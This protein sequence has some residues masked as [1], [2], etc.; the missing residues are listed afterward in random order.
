MTIMEPSRLAKMFALIGTVTLLALAIACAKAPLPSSANSKASAANSIKRL[1]EAASDFRAELTTDRNEIVAQ[2]PTSLILNVRNAKGEIVRDLPPVHEKPIHLI[3]VSGDLA[4]FNHLHP[5][6]QPDGSYRVG[7][8]FPHGGSYRLY[9]DFTPT[10]A[11]QIVERYS[12][13][14]SGT[15]AQ[16]VTLME[17][18]SFAKSSEGLRVNMQPSA[19]LRAGREVQL[20][21][22][23]TDEASGKPVTDLQPYLGSL[24]HFVI[25]T[26][27][28]TKYLHVHP[29]EAGAMPGMNDEGMMG[30]MD[31]QMDA[32]PPR[33]AASKLTVSAH[34]TFADAGLYKLWAQFQRAGRVITIP[35]I[36][37]VNGGETADAKPK[38][39][40]SLP[41][42]AIKVTVGNAGYE[43][44]RIEV[45]QGRSV[46]LAFYRVD[47]KNCGGEVVFP[48]LGIRKPLPVG[49]IT[50][51]EVTPKASGDLAFTCG[52]G[53]L[54]GTIVVQ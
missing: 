31:E 20:D 26:E 27:D 44:A 8:T 1:T 6:L 52:A 43:P 33:K 17:D 50:L 30:K 45:K 46:R 4:E 16:R 12:V 40:D 7:F 49:K 25:I 13:D 34:T 2:Q 41:P 9:A 28:T 29:M 22:S 5:E 48:A 23:V 35:F 10:G 19:P 51:V 18:K 39:S 54:R 37:R 32:G 24:A 42:G 15:P 36:L 47:A 14:V 11:S 53:M 38:D 21:F 3:L